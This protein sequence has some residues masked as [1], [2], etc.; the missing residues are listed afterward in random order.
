MNWIPLLSVFTAQVVWKQRISVPASWCPGVTQQFG[1]FLW[2]MPTEMSNLDLKSDCLLP[3]G[4]VRNHTE[5]A[6][7]HIWGQ[8]AATILYR[9]HFTYSTFPLSHLETVSASEASIHTPVCNF[10]LLESQCWVYFSHRWL[11]PL[12][13]CVQMWEE[14]IVLAVENSASRICWNTQQNTQWHFPVFMIRFQ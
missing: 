13:F 1:F 5:F 3:P 9:R 11:V 7:E 14:N 12:F 6:V 10:L 4:T 8:D 2:E